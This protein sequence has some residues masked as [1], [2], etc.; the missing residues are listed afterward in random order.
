VRSPLKQQVWVQ[1]P[2]R[3]NGSP[4]CQRST[5]AAIIF[6]KKFI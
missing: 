3:P 2:D 4:T 5:S 1:F 6:R